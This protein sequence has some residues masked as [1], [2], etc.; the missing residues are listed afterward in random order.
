VNCARGGCCRGGSS[1][2]LD[3]GKVAG[4]A[5]DVFAE[6]SGRQERPVRRANVVC[7]PHLGASTT[8]A[9][10]NVAVQIAEQMADYLTTG[11]V[12]HAL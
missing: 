7:T 10:E 3:S 12:R 11:A 1:R 8:E 9:Q 6:E 4:A 2:G 5:F